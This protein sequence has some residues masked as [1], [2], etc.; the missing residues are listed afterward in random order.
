MILTTGFTG[1]FVDREAES[2]GLDF[3]D[4]EYVYWSRLTT[5]LT[6]CR[7]AKRDASQQAEQGLN[8]SGASF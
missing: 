1:A 4:K 6:L 8:N 5:T 3:I 2:K 7:R